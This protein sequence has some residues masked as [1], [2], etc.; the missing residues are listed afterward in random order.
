M[1]EIMKYHDLLLNIELEI[2]V[3]IDVTPDTLKDEHNDDVYR[4]MLASIKLLES[5]PQWENV[6]C[7]MMNDLIFEIGRGEIIRH[8][9]SCIEYFLLIEEYLTCAELSRLEKTFT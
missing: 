4:A 7:F 3:F 8:I 1:K 6:P 5:N 2:P 9:N